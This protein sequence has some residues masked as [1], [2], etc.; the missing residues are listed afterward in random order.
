[1][2]SFEIKIAVL[3]NS[4]SGKKTVVNALLCDNYGGAVLG[5]GKNTAEVICYRANF[6]GKSTSENYCIPDLKL[7]SDETI[8]IGDEEIKETVYDIDVEKSFVE[9]RSDT[10]FSFVIV[11]G[12]DIKFESFVAEKWDTF[13]AVLAILDGKKGLKEDDE[14][15]LKLL[16]EKQDERCLPLIILCNKIDDPED[17]KLSK[18][19]KKAQNKVEKILGVNT[20]LP[21]FIPISAIQAYVYRAGAQM[22][23]RQFEDFDKDMMVSLQYEDVI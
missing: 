11:P 17:E 5:K 14:N 20:S 12:G 10:R 21:T 3:G 9:T 8:K 15:L 16:K 23:A 13:D 18:H 4:T 2:A 6:V 22:T 19:A 7:H 1:M